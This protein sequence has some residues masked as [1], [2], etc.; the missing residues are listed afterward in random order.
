MITGIFNF[1]GGLLGFA[2][3]RQEIKAEQAEAHRELSA[4]NGKPLSWRNGI[5]WVCT[6]ILAYHWIIRDLILWTCNEIGYELKAGLPL[7]DEGMIYKLI[8][9][10]LGI[11]D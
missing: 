9:G 6:L 4:P 8:F 5:G 1:L 11:M 7:V 2:S 10:M 3:K